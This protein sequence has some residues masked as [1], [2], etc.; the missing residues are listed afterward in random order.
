MLN[1]IHFNPQAVTDAVQQA[2]QFL[3]REQHPDGCW[4]DYQ[5]EPGA[6]EAWTTAVVLW[7]LACVQPCS[8]ALPSVRAAVDAL[9]ALQKTTG[10]GY[11]RHTAADADST[12][13]TCRVLTALS[14]RSDLPAAA[15]LRPFILD[16][17]SSQTF[18]G[19]ER[20]GSW[21]GYHADVQPMI[22]IALVRLFA[23]TNDPALPVL[24]RLMRSCCM[25]SVK[26]EG[27]SSF[28]WTTDAYAIACNLEFL[29]SSGGIPGSIA[30]SAANWLADAV[31]PQSAFEAAQYLMIAL[32]TG[33]EMEK[34]IAYLMDTQLDD[35][36]WPSS[37]VLLVPAQFNERQ[38]IQQAAFA[39]IRRLMST[40]MALISLKRVLS[41]TRLLMN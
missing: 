11:N 28:W 13:W 36:S 21:A 32:L 41:V 26:P 37:G 18:C 15:L 40:A 31:A 4:R 14:S 19:K 20:F 10:W 12:A 30:H 34:Y 22:G 17:G 2:E 33:T 9:H 5:L 35:G 39:D 6:S 7:S 1:L 23:A 29:Q 24:I 3:V 8:V 25:V 27:W 16:D 38:T